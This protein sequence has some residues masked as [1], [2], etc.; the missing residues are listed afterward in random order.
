MRPPPRLCAPRPSG[1]RR[2]GWNATPPRRSLR[3]PRRTGKA[4]KGAAAA[5]CRTFWTDKRRKAATADA[6]P[7]FV[8]SAEPTGPARSGRPDDKLRAAHAD[9]AGNATRGH[10]AWRLSLPYVGSTRAAFARCRRYP[11]CDGADVA[12]VSAAA[13]AEQAQSVVAA[14]IEHQLG[15]AFRLAFLQMIELVQLIR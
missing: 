3:P 8:G 4:R 5:A 6:T 11:A 1:S 14:Q 9:S 10:G 13:A 7:W 12:I 2:C 15:E